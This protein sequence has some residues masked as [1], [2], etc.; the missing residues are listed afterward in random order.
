MAKDSRRKDC[1]VFEWAYALSPIRAK[2]YAMWPRA[3]LEVGTISQRNLL[4]RLGAQDLAAPKKL[5]I[6]SSAAPL[7]I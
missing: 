3:L 1:N 6:T 5:L 2:I 7:N 4:R